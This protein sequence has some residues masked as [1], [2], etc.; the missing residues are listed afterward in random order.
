MKE[1]RTILKTLLRQYHSKVHFQRP[2]AIS[3]PYIVFDL[4]NSYT[5]EELEVLSLDVDIWDNQSDTT[6]LETLAGTL[7]KALHKLT[8]LDEHMQFSIH[9]ESR[10]TVID[11]DPNIKR[12]KLIFSVRYF[13]R[14]LNE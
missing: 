6:T 7:W 2:T 5:D 4:P 3:F 1:L 13:D 9:R 11:D 14:R 8:Y 10:L 12:R